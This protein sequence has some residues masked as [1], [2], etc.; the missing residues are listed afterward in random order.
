MGRHTSGRFQPNVSDET[1]LLVFAQHDDPVLSTAEV[2]RELSLH[3]PTV[4]R[5]LR[6][7]ADTGHLEYK[8]IGVDE[9]AAAWWLPGSHPNWERNE[10]S[11]ETF[12]RQY[13]HGE[14]DT[15][16]FEQKLERVLAKKVADETSED[17]V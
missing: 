15:M 7:L 3:Y 10:A 6:R 16:E 1:L 9:R 8:K 5:R 17:A 4:Y 14:I 2:A 13:I 12:K 11:I